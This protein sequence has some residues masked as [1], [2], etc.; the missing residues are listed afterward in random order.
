[1][2]GTSTA[3]CLGCAGLGYQWDTRNRLQEID[4]GTYYPPHVVGKFSY[5]SFGRRTSKTD[6]NGNTTTYLYDGDN[7]IQ[8]TQGSTVTTLLTG[9]GIDERYARDDAAYGRTYFLTDALGS[10]LAL[11]DTTGAVKQTY[12]YEPYGEVTSSGSSD[13]PYQ[14]TGS[15]HRAGER[16]EPLLLPGAVLLTES[17]AVH[18]RRPH[19]VGSGVE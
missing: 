3:G 4:S 2:T 5:D 11:T 12:A 19:G 13:N 7:P 17:E 16:W 10:T 18:L 1:M 15:I 6:S 14:Y 8:E 9:L